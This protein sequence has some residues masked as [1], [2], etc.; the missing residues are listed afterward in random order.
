ML[1]SQGQGGLA[2]CMQVS[3]SYT[4]LAHPSRRPDLTANDRC[5]STLGEQRK[6][7]LMSRETA[8]RKVPCLTLWRVRTAV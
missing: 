6:N 7:I 4:A 2:A 5:H 3:V 1:L 8:A